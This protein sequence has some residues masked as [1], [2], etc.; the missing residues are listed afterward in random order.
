MSQPLTD[1]SLSLPLKSLG[2]PHSL[3]CM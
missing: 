1:I 2:A 3:T